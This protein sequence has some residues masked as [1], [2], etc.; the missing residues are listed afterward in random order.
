MKT[1]EKINENE[2]NT[3]SKKKESTEEKKEKKENEINTDSKKKELNEEKKEK[4]ENT[5]DT[6]FNNFFDD[7][8]EFPLRLSNQLK[9]L[10]IRQ[11]FEEE[12]RIPVTNLDEFFKMCEKKYNKYDDIPVTNIR[13][14]FEL[15][16]KTPIKS[17]KPI[18]KENKKPYKEFSKSYISTT[19]YK[20]G[21][22][23]DETKQIL[24]NEN[25]EEEIIKEKLVDGKGKKTIT[26]NGKNKTIHEKKL[27]PEITLSQR[28]PIHNIFNDYGLFDLR[29]RKVYNPFVTRFL[30]M[31]LVF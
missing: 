28:L 17:E 26:K 3:D 19:I 31:E 13:E 6:L 16:E 29:P 8:F 20:N 14:F 5:I 1:E 21:H 4:K 25:G 15:C 30:P 24:R 12:K 23:I 7:F 11:K 18:K 27:L 9:D 10:S 2:I 22:R